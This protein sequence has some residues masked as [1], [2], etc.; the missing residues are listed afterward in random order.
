MKTHKPFSLLSW[1]LLT[2][3][4]FILGILLIL[5]LAGILEG[6]NLDFQTPLGFISLS[7]GF[8]QWLL[9]RKYIE[10]S[11]NWVG[12][13]FIAITSVFL[14]FDIL[15]PVFRLDIQIYL[16][17]LFVVGSLLSGY[18]QYRY[19]LRKVSDKAVLWNL[20]NLAGWLACVLLLQVIQI[21]Y[22]KTLGRNVDTYINLTAFIL[23]GPML[24]LITGIGIRKILSVKKEI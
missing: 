4:G 18:L 7:I 14:M 2:T 1:T 5:L 12:F 8:L 11:F 23:C 17:P 13:S 3:A 15:H 20:Y 22:F 10:K 6:L 16:F 19:L 21:H 24:G 9:L